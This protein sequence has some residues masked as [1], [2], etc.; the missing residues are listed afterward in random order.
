MGISAAIAK[1]VAEYHGR[2]DL[3]GL[4]GIVSTAFCI[5][6]VGGLAMSAGL[7]IVSGRTDLFFPALQPDGHLVMRDLL[8]IAALYS[9]ILWP[10]TLIKG[11]AIGLLRYDLMVMVSS[12]VQGVLGLATWALLTRGAGV[13]VLLAITVGS[14]IIG[15]VLL[16]VL[17]MHRTPGFAIRI[18][19]FD[20]RA[21]R[22]LFAYSSLQFGV[23]IASLVIFQLDSLV[24]GAF[25][26]IAA[27]TSYEVAFRLQSGA[28]LIAGILG[29]PVTPASSE[30]DSQGQ[31]DRER[32]LFLKGTRFLS[33]AI[34][35]VVTVIIVFAKP[36]IRFWMGIGFEAAVFPTQVLIAFWYMNVMT[37]VGAS[38][39]AGKGILRPQLIAAV[40]NAVLN[41][42]ISI[43]LA[44]RFGILGVA[45]G[46]TIPM[47]L[48]GGGLL[49]SILDRLSV[50]LREFFR[51]VVG[52]ALELTIVT[53]IL[54][55]SVRLFVPQGLVQTLVE[56][57]LILGIAYG[58]VYF[59]LDPASRRLLGS[60]VGF[61]SR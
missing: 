5:Y 8:L 20:S 50:S 19:F 60:L 3:R 9:P 40:T 35:P 61:V 32:V 4:S 14:Q 28:R 53:A 7:Y 15:N 43:T 36:L 39:L 55:L 41:L 56:I 38:I 44:T 27:V 49:I 1:Y 21:L 47:I 52:P 33:S 2:S 13:E 48:C 57:S 31:T 16:L 12:G 6:C 23:Q 17:L 22:K 30:L 25:V 45:L 59:R 26:S 42:A 29:S 18:G 11:V 51:F 46:T 34:L 10:T 54:A 24:V 58:L 37:D